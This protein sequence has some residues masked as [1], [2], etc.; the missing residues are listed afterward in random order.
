MPGLDQFLLTATEDFLNA[1]EL[2]AAKPS[3]A[4]QSD[5]LKPE[6]CHFIITLDMHVRKFV[7]VACIKEEA[8]RTD[9]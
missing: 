8:V 4:L 9:S 1:S 6:L 5:R 2:C 7:T 3:I